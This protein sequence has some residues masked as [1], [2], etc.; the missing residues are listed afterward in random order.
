[1]PVS[2]GI[3]IT[4]VEPALKATFDGRNG[5][6]Y[7]ACY[8]SFPPDRRLVV[9]QNAVGGVHVVGLP[10]V[11]RDPIG[12]ELCH[13]VRA[14]RIELRQLTSRRVL[15]RSEQLRGRGLIKADTVLHL[16]DADGV[17]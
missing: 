4:Q 5:A 9:E 3:Q 17:E 8:E 16:E 12:V 14:S 2:L 7:F 15:H 6:R 1:T 11:D 10:V 13:R